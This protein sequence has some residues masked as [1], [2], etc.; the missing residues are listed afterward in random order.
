LVSLQ[1]AAKAVG[2]KGEFSQNVAEAVF[3][4][5]LARRSP[6]NQYA[7]ESATGYFQLYRARIGLIAASILLLVSAVGLSGV[8]FMEAAI[9]ARETDSIRRQAMFYDERYR[10]ARARLPETP[11]ESRQIKLAV[12]MAEKLMSYKTSPQKM[13]VT[14]SLGL[15]RFPQLRI[16]LVNWKS[17]VDPDAPVDGQGQGAA[18]AQNRSGGAALPALPEGEARTLYQL[19]NIRGQ[20]SPFDGNYRRALDLVNGF[21]ETLRGLPGVHHVRIQTLPLNV[22]SESTLEGDAIRS[23]GT[24]EANFELRIAIE[25][26]PD[27]A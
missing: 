16:D 21:A 15:E 25:D 7:P 22:D 20:I 17:S 1:Q 10:V 14:L 19:A 26:K 4:Q 18:S 5:A 8:K 11:A 23:A 12:E 2:I 3:A 13:L 9:A 24:R 6:P 27:E